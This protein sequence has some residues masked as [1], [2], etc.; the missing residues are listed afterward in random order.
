MLNIFPKA[1]SIGNIKPAAKELKLAEIIDLFNAAYESYRILT[2]PDKTTETFHKDWSHLEKRWK[3]Q[4]W[5]WHRD[6]A[7]IYDRPKLPFFKSIAI[8]NGF[9]SPC[10]NRRLLR[11]NQKTNWPY[12]RLHTTHA[13]AFWYCKIY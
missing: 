7:L 8:F 10:K 3:V 2:C 11:T 4:N 12:R 1:T 5:L 6:V 13:H 9:L